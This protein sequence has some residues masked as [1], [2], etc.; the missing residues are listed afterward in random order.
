MNENVYLDHNA[1][2]PLRPEARLAI[3]QAMGIVGN[4]SSVHAGGRAA[5]RII[6]DARRVVAALCAAQPDTVTFTSGGT[7]ANNLALGATA[8]SRVLIS[9]VEHPS[10][11]DVADRPEIIPV[12]RDG[13][14][15]LDA[16]E[17]M[18]ASDNTP[19]L[20]SVMA[21]NNETG[22]IQ[23]I[24]RVAEVTRRYGGIV[25][26]DGVQAVGKIPLD[27]NS[28][29][30]H[31]LTIS[32]HKIGG[33]AGSGALINV[34]GLALSPLIRGGGQEKKLRPGTE[35]LIGIAGFGAAAQVINDRGQAEIEK[36]RQWRDDLESAAKN[37]ILGLEIVG[38][39]APRLPNTSALISPAIDSETQVMAL[40][41]DGVSISSG[42]ACSSGKVGAS[43][44]MVAMGFNDSQA[45]SVI[46]VSLGWSSRPD[47]TKRFLDVWCGLHDRLARQAS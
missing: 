26:C 23:P 28:L 15:D 14:V 3:D 20:V 16:L 42:S 33:P 43:P 29:G 25:H 36:I 19:A 6:E 9:A 47:D 8:M 40:D 2:A 21:A 18:L 12:D 27:V 10:V 39:S 13:I 31:M 34:D 7:E 22:V 45:R 35:N 37:R 5:R 24:E 41:I 17:N 46:R 30:V 11:Y 38:Q 4:G 44:V 1:T 32:G